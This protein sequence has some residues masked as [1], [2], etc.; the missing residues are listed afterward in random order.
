MSWRSRQKIS[1][2][3]S[4]ASGAERP[5]NL[6]PCR[7]TESLD[8]LI[9]R[10]VRRIPQVK[11]AGV[12]TMEIAPGCAHA[13]VREIQYERQVWSCIAAG[14]VGWFVDDTGSLRCSSVLRGRRGTELGF[15]TDRSKSPALHGRSTALR[16]SR[17]VD[18]QSHVPGDALHPIH[19]PLDAYPSPPA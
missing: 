11:A 17:A 2:P 9:A 1:R 19:R 12:H 7:L 3:G 8:L 13:P 5:V 6:A 14:D 4:S 10:R 15:R 18:Q 16:N